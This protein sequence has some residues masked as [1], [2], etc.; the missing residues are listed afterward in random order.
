MDSISYSNWLIGFDS[1]ISRMSYSLKNNT[2]R[3][4]REQEFI[5][6]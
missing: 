5:Y 4:Y 1:S 2:L 6:V 3:W